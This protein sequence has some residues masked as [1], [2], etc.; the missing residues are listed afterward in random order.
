M[1]GRGRAWVRAN[2]TPHLREGE[3]G[4]TVFKSKH[5]ARRCRKTV[6]NSFRVYWCDVC[7]GWHISRK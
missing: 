6:K 4:K 1:A 3:C 7:V 2:Y 5:A